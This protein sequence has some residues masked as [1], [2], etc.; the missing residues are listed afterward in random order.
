MDDYVRAAS[1]NTV[2]LPISDEVLFAQY[3]SEFLLTEKGVDHLN[4]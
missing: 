2:Q 3:W 4:R 1:S